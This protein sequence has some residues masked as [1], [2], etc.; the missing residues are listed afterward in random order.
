MFNYI[1]YILFGYVFYHFNNEIESLKSKNKLY[2]S[3]IECLHEKIQN[4]STNTNTNIDF[5][6]T[7][8]GL[9][10]MSR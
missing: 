3:N 1:L 10:L 7:Q 8:V 4:L 5:I 9:E 6:K 2:E